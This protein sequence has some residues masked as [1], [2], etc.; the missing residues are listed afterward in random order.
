MEFLGVGPTELLFI[1]AIALIV[2]GPKDMAKTGR[3]VGKWLNNLIQSDTWKVVQ[4][5]SKE[6]RNL[7]TQLMREDNLE[8]YLTE[9]NEK[10]R[11][12]TKADTWSGQ[13]GAKPNR[14]SLRPDD[15]AEPKNENIIHPPVVV[16]GPPAADLEPE[17][18]KPAKTTPSTLRQAQD[19][20]S[21]KTGPKKFPAAK[22]TNGK[23]ARKTV[24]TVK[25]S[26]GTRTPRKKPNA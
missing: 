3:T 26:T 25:T 19:N 20:A 6:L 2:L 16:T 18:N 1:I 13:A 10:P 24:S 9:G 22:E 12:G 11:T 5:T 14:A 23:T 17:K 8:K 21:L 4:K 7:P 15:G